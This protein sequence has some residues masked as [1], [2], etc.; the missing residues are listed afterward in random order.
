MRAQ[1][2]GANGPSLRTNGGAGFR[3]GKPRAA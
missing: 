2:I 3:G 1:N